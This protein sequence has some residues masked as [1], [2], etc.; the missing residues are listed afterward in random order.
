M[1]SKRLVSKLLAPIL[2]IKYLVMPQES[3]KDGDCSCRGSRTQTFQT[4]SCA[5]VCVDVFFVWLN[6]ICTFSTMYSPEN[7]ILNLSQITCKSLT[8]LK[9]G[10]SHKWKG[11]NSY[12]TFIGLPKW[13]M[14]MYLFYNHYL[15]C[16]GQWP[17]GECP[18]VFPMM[19]DYKW[20]F[21]L[22]EHN[23]YTLE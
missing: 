18:W 4:P 22:C 2:T 1:F 14:V 10:Y 21:F 3:N 23:T 12:F 9:S 5:Y 11:Q 19:M 20:I 15:Y 8:F 6:E 16:A 13:Q 17:F 7:N